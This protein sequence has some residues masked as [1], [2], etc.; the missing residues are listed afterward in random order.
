[1]L[2]TFTSARVIADAI[3]SYLAAHPKASDTAHAVAHW[4]LLREQVQASEEDV[5]AALEHLIET[6]E[7]EKQRLSS[8]ETVYGACR[9]PESRRDK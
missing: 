1:M 3:R 9:R 2:Y 6:G 5:V 8:G 4:W 7:V